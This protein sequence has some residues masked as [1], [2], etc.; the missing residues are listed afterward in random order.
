MLRGGAVEPGHLPLIASINAALDAL[1]GM[2]IAA[3]AAS[4]AVVSD[5]G[6]EIRLT[7]YSEAGAVGTTVLDPIRA[8]ALAQ[9]L[10]TAALLRLSS[11]I[12]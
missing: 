5:D 1:D 8:I 9:R 4:R 6:G 12:G 3:D 2:P 11:R 10:I 7:L